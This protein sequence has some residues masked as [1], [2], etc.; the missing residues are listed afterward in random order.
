MPITV[1]TTF[2]AAFSVFTPLL[3]RYALATMHEIGQDVQVVWTKMLQS[4]P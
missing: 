4:L 3:V 2:E 1:L